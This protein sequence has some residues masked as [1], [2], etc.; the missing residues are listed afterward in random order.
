MGADA[1]NHLSKKRE[2]A[3]IFVLKSGADRSDFVDDLSSQLVLEERGPTFVRHL[4][5][6][7]WDLSVDWRRGERLH[8]VFERKG[9]GR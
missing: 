2:S 6:V 7:C 4:A 5:S 1:R 3:D 9:S 8:A